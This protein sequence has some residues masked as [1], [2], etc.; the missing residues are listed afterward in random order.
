MA[1][2]KQFDE[3]AVIERAMTLFWEKGYGATAMADLADATGV[4]RG[5]LYNA[6]G[7]KDAIMMRAMD[8][9][10]EQQGARARDALQGSDVRESISGFLDAHLARMADTNNPTGCLMCQT[11][12]ELGDQES[13]IADAV[14]GQFRRTE[15]ALFQVLQS[16]REHGQLSGDTDARA[17]ALFYLGVSRGMAVMHRAYRD[18]APV[19]SIAHV[20]MKALD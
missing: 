7:G 17:L 6:Y 3:N 11:A 18:L 19:Q 15:D 5:S 9:Y 1:G 14:R 8:L 12:L 20:A 2:V 10:A 4:Q 13:E 16:A